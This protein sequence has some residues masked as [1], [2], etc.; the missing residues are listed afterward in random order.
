[1][2]LSIRIV[3]IS[4]NFTSM[5]RT[6]LIKPRK[7]AVFPR[8]RRLFCTKEPYEF[9]ACVEASLSCS[10][11]SF[12][13]VISCLSR[14]FHVSTQLLAGNLTIP[15]HALIAHF[16]DLIQFS[17]ECH[18]CHHNTQSLMEF[19]TIRMLLRQTAPLMY[20][21]PEILIFIV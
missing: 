12:P 1:M 5:N 13:G 17:N 16:Q 3:L 11:S 9:R 7:S 18:T 6:F 2:L 19:N 20:I 10:V 4:S 21:Y 15:T 8:K 14:K